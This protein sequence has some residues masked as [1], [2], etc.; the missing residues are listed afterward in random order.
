MVKDRIKPE[1]IKGLKVRGVILESG[2]NDF[3]F[4]ISPKR[5]DLNSYSDLKRRVQKV[6]RKED[7]FKGLEN[8][9]IEEGLRK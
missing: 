5:R 7:I 2:T 9:A 3:E 6:E 1:K 8:L 4:E